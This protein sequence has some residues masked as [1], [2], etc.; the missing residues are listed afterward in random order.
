MNAAGL[1]QR[2][3]AAHLQGDTSEL[4]NIAEQTLADLK[5]ADKQGV[6]KLELVNLSIALRDAGKF[7]HA[8]RVAEATLRRN[9]DYPY[10]W[11]ELAISRL[12]QGRHADALIAVDELMRRHPNDV[13]GM[14]LAAQL[15]AL[16]GDSARAKAEIVKLRVLSPTHPDH[17]V[18]SDFVDYVAEFPRERSLYLC[19]KLELSTRFIGTKEIA[20]RATEALDSDRGFSFI[21]VGDGEGAFAWL[22][23]A[24]ESGYANLYAHNREDRA[25][26]WFDGQ[27]ELEAS[28]FLGLAL[29]LRETIARADILGIPYSTWVSHEYKIGSMTGLSALTNM[30]RLCH[31]P[32]VSV[33]HALSRQ[34][35]HFALDQDGH[36]KQLLIGTGTVGLIGCHPELPAFMRKVFG[37]TD[38]EFH[39]IPGERIFVEKIGAEAAEGVHFPVRFYEIMAALT[40]RNLAGRLYLVAGGILGKFYCDKIKRQ[41]GVALDIGS[42]VDR[43]I[44]VATRPG[45][46]QT[47]NV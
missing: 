20:R 23:D 21:R 37:V 25:R 3:R 36:L 8:D 43:W 7:A 29:T 26:V 31:E 46:Q 4:T 28:G 38:I 40:D 6:D 17:G 19:R 27:I 10:A 30:L 42:V 24:D 14:V 2:A 47:K 16:V 39:K 13:R 11:Y 34:D 32:D 35:A 18:L 15:A 9:S 12:L 22:S 41:G 1:A 5:G 45:F 44:G 33:G